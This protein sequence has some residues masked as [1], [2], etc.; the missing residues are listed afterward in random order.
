MIDLLGYYDKIS[1]TFQQ[2]DTNQDK[3][4]SF[5]EFKKGHELLGEDSSNES[6]LRREFNS[7]DTNHGGYILFDEVRFLKLIYPG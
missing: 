1:E 3:R 7:I 2:L 4:I 5:A 6:E